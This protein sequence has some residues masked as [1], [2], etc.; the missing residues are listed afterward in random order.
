MS[1]CLKRV[2]PAGDS[3]R[4]TA[5]VFAQVPGQAKPF[6]RYYFE[7]GNDQAGWHDTAIIV[8]DVAPGH[9]EGTTFSNALAVAVEWVSEASLLAPHLASE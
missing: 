8:K 6:V 1:L 5:R 9:D 3:L 7:R 4:I 2:F